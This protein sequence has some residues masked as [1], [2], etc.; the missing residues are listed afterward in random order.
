MGKR[1]LY[2]QTFGCQM[3]VH[4]SEKIMALMGSSGYV[5]TDDLVE[6]DLIIVN[7]CSIREKAKQ[8]IYSELG[9]FRKL[10]EQRPDIIIGVGGCLAQ[11]K[12]S[13][14][15]RKYP[16]LDL[17][18]GT[19]NIH[20]IPEYVKNIE[21][22]RAAVISTDF[23]ES[24][25]SLNVVAV[26]QNGKISAY[27]TIMQGCN[28]FC[29]FCVVP[30]LRGRE[31]SRALTD[32]IKEVNILADHGVK[33]VILLGQN[34]NSYGKSPGN[35]HDFPELLQ[36]IGKIDDI[37]RIRFTTSHPKDLSER[38]MTSF[39]TVDKLCEHIH[40]PVQS[41]SD[42]ILGMMN[43]CYT[44]ADYLDKVK[45][46]RSI[47]PDISIT[48]DFI[49][50]FP[51]EEDWDFQATLDLMK[52]IKF[53]GAFSFKYSER[54][55][56][57]AIDIK[58]KIPE[59]VKRERLQVLQSLQGKHTL[60]R[61]ALLI[62][63]IEEILVEGFSKKCRDDMIGRT[64]TNRIVNFR[65]ESELIGKTVSVVITDAYQHSLRGILL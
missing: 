39:K 37:E 40:L 41:G 65:G 1:R 8:K 48:S 55:G 57:A 10:K 33:E 50:G 19:H 3:N 15:L 5:T 21:I 31:E 22:S 20:R 34:V 49:V 51:G 45:S 52:I 35:G 43:R 17:V 28:N 62:G 14:F 56:T 26:P 24:V 16:F 4:D 11:Q 47:C 36:E 60:E 54:V 59:C 38:L 32:I 9:R 44:S 13:E 46:L 12:G 18:F 64:R 58:K 2:I 6:A 23:Q 53:D 25:E 29:S 27:V 61:H 7:T 42:R 63:N 30:Y